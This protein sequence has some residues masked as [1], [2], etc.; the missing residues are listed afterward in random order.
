M[1]TVHGIAESPIMIESK[2]IITETSQARKGLKRKA[3]ASCPLTKGEIID[4]E[5]PL[6]G[7]IPESQSKYDFT[8]AFFT[9][10]DKEK[11]KFQWLK[12]NF[13]ASPY[14]LKGTDEVKMQEIAQRHGVTLAKVKTVYKI[15]A[16][17]AWYTPDHAD[18]YG[19]LFHRFSQINHS[20]EANAKFARGDGP[21][22]SW[23][24]EARRPIEK[25]E[26][27]TLCYEVDLCEGE[28]GERQAKLRSAF[29]FDCTCRKCVRE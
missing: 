5:A 10:F 6:L 19:V 13:H 16:T 24:L 20:C 1:E 2:L 18:S 11:D 14:F 29:G 8:S 26:E 22:Y 15:I 7:P 23:T 9:R 17:N 3:I 12:A 4:R 28:K 21:D 25:D 27:I